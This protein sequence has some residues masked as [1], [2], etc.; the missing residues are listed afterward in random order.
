VKFDWKGALL[1]SNQFYGI[2]AV[3]LAIESNVLLLHTIPNAFLLLTIHLVTVLYYTHAYL[4]EEQEGIYNDRSNWYQKH[5]RY[6]KFRQI[7]YTIACVWLLV[8][9][10]AA[11]QLFLHA[12][13]TIQLIIIASFAL[14]AVYYLPNYA[15]FPF[16]S[17]RNKGILKSAAIAWVWTVLCCMIPLWFS[18]ELNFLTLLSSVSFWAHFIQLYFFILILAILFD[19]KDLYRDKEAFVNTLVVKHG[20]DFTIYKIVLPLLLLSF[21]FTLLGHYW[22][23][24]SLM[25]LLS[26]LFILVLIYIV[27]R[28][29]VHQ[30]AIHINM[31]LI[32][33]LMIIKAILSIIVVY[34]IH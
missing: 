4:H 28:I 7:I 6:L 19:I 34:M 29:V 30:K 32:D 26:R 18:M 20:V 12:P 14:S 11:I 25:H 23:G 31:L 24:G 17:F 15:F 10:L 8:V 9:K 2:C 27:S 5:Q 16:T 13:L 21:L 3:L 1:W 33:G 22:Q